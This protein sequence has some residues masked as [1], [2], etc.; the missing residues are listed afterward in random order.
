MQN[1]AAPSED[2]AEAIVSTLPIRNWPDH[3]QRGFAAAA[4]GAGE[5][6]RPAPQ[7]GDV[8]ICC[9]DADGSALDIA[10]AAA[11]AAGVGDIVDIADAPMRARAWAPSRQADFVAVNP[12]W[13]KRVALELDAMAEADDGGDGAV[14][15]EEERAAA[16]AEE[17]AAWDDLRYFLRDSG[18]VAPGGDAWI[19]S[20]DP[21]LTAAL[22]MKAAR[23]IALSIA[24]MDCRW[25]RYGIR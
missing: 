5:A 18:A 9:S 23:K 12:P 20:G 21:S 10:R 3:S 1:C 17:A 6:A 16:L 2:A 19:L 25:L 7:C 14:S 13:G 24:G 15:P 22:K 4:L 11:A 8:R